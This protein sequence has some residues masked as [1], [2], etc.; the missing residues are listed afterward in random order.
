M[1]EA[2]LY[3]TREEN[4]TK[5]E[6]DKVVQLGVRDSVAKAFESLKETNKVKD[7]ASVKVLF[8]KDKGAYKLVTE[9]ISAAQN[10]KLMGNLERFTTPEAEQRWAADRQ[11]G[12]A[13][14]EASR[15][16]ARDVASKSGGAKNKRDEMVGKGELDKADL[17][18]DRDGAIKVYPALSQKDDYRKLVVQTGSDSKYFGKPA[19]QAH[20]SLITAVPDKFAEYTGPEAQQRFAR[21]FAEKTAGKSHSDVETARS[22][23]TARTGASFMAQFKDRGFLLADPTRGK[24]MHEKG[25]SAMRSAT[26]EQ[27]EAVMKVSNR[28]LAPLN[29]KEVQLRADVAG[30]PVEEMAKKGFAEQRELS[31]DAS[32]KSPSLT[33]EDRQKQQALA[34]GLTAMRAELESRNEGRDMSRSQ[35]AGKQAGEEKAQGERKAPQSMSKGVEQDQSVDNTLELL[36][37]GRRNRTGNGR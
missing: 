16:A 15:N 30:I 9:G 6:G 18:A 19:E 24:D 23:A 22:A 28:L 14:T 2:Y 27:I 12:I 20:Y 34:R 7:D 10:K 37:V 36:S 5:R 8:D 11:A 17:P 3:S 32:G 25:L 4:G 13:E 21:E 26:K 29:R 33:G 31:K 35:D 1:A